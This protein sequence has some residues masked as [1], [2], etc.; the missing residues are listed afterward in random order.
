MDSI[1]GCTKICFVAFDRWLDKLPSEPAIKA[2]NKSDAGHTL[3][4]ASIS[5]L[6]T[7]L[8]PKSNQLGA[9]PATIRSVA[10]V[11]DRVAVENLLFRFRIWAEHNSALSERHDSLDWRLR[12]SSMT[13]SVM[14]DLLTDLSHAILSMLPSLPER[15]TLITI[16]AV[17]IEVADASAEAVQT[18]VQT[19][20]NQLF[21][22]SRTIRRSGCLRRVAKATDYIDYDELGND[23]N[24][25]FR[26]STQRYLE[27]V[28]GDKSDYLRARLLETIC[29]RQQS[30]AFQRSRRADSVT[31]PIE[32]PNK[33]AQHDLG[34]LPSSK[35]TNSGG[36]KQLQSRSST[37]TSSLVRRS[38]LAPSSAT[39][40]VSKSVSFGEK[41]EQTPNITFLPEDLPR[42]PKVS[43]DRHKKEQECPYCF[44][45]CPVEEFT[46]SAWS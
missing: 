42:I 3:Q 33:D 46:G 29:M 10:E 26:D 9:V 21:C 41:R 40:F 34:T 8:L 45:M 18:D 32:A 6:G 25:K 16:A 44:V 23:L 12:K 38:S 35:V 22:F 2:Q 43:D 19:M 7:Q 37:T 11:E 5:K 4:D 17:R 15:S 20:L 27:I 24:A 31:P 13:H 39:T 1:R 14:I 36:P 30:F 28:V